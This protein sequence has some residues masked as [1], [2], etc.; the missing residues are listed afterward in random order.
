[1][2]EKY[3]RR[4]LQLASLGAGHVAPNPMVGAVLVNDNRVI[5]EGYHRVYGEG[6]AEV[7]C[8]RSVSADNR[9]LISRSTLYVSLEPCNH[10]GKT[11]P[12]TDIIL[13]HAIP[14]VVIGCRDIHEK[15]NGSGVETLRRAGVEVIEDVCSEDAIHLNRRFFTFHGKRRPYIILKWACS[16]DGFIGQEDNRV[17][18]SNSI[19]NR[20]VHRWR[21]E[22]SAILIGTATA[23]IDNPS[24]T[25]R[26]WPGPHPVR[27]VIDLQN[28]LSSGLSIFDK[29]SR[30]IIVN[31]SRESD[32]GNII[33]RKVSEGKDILRQILDILYRENLQSV[34]VEGGRR[35]L[36]SFIDAGLWD[37]ARII[38]N[39]SLK[40]GSGVRA[41]V[42]SVSNPFK[43]EALANDSVSFFHNC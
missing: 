27:V 10:F 31:I 42:L 15:V 17:M 28:K 38:T 16:A 5:G 20:L 37:E 13:E 33:Y 21:A 6:H 35:M 25:T 39:N 22:E 24:L 12:C 29:Q 34:I 1:M 43:E 40:L 18:I 7:N 41:P 23:E 2:N 14:R 4:C 36:Q 9:H 19:T 3:M 26:H 11:P 32:D 30:T 8:I